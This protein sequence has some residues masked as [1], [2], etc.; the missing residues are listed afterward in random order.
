MAKFLGKVLYRMY[1]K[2]YLPSTAQ[3]LRCMYMLPAFRRNPIQTIGPIIITIAV[4][5]TDPVKK[6]EIG[7]KILAL[8][9]FIAS[10]PVTYI[11]NPILIA[12][13]DNMVLAPI[14]WTTNECNF[15]ILI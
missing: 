10:S 3:Y 6:F 9:R 8:S 12:S 1:S 11:P 13:I 2:R 5:T 4:L 7:I 14:K 15:L